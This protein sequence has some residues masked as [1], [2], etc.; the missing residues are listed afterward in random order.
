MSSVSSLTFETFLGFHSRLDDSFF[1]NLTDTLI[2]GGSG[3]KTAFENDRYWKRNANPGIEF[4]RMKIRA[5]V[6]LSETWAKEISLFAR[7]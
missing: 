3:P 6:A 7:K 1:E 2:E 5:L 4:Q